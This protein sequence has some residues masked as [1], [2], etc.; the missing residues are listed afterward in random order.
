MR[1]LVFAEHREDRIVKSGLEVVS[2]GREIADK[3]DGELSVAVIGSEIEVL[4]E[5]ISAYGADK[6]ILADCRDQKTPR[7][8]LY[9]TVI[10][11]IARSESSE[12]IL[13]AFSSLGKDLVPA[14]AAKLG[15]SAVS[16]C[17]GLD[18][19]NGELRCEKPVYGDKVIEV[20]SL[21]EKPV[22]MSLRPNIFPIKEQQKPSIIDNFSVTVPAN[23]L[24][25]VLRDV[26]NY[27]RTRPDL[28]EAN[29]VVAGG[30]GFSKPENFTMLE[31]LADTLGA[32]VAA[33]RSVVDAGWRPQ[34]EQVGQTGKAISPDLYIACG[35]SGAIQHI[36]G[37]RS[38]K[39]IV[40]INSDRD[41]S[42]FKIADYGIVGDL[43]E[44]IPALINEIK[45]NRQA[46]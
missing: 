11:D 35:I 24:R 36:A 33:S 29:I 15:V 38:S 37:M 6:I 45:R 20:L 3:T 27:E 23:D 42:I 17:T 2:L 31:D 46:K 1:T 8:S 25:T 10:S 5:E 14:M 12:L 16:N 40:A 13:S 18:F 9:S 28:T 21:S 32:A 26:S 30:R 44:I 22:V 41:A 43:F 39:C 19:T 34:S 7:S 4:S